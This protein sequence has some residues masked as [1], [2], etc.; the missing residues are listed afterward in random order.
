MAAASGPR[1]D[2]SGSSWTP[3]SRLG[4]LTTR[5]P[6]SSKPSDEPVPLRVVLP[7]S[8]DELVDAGLAVHEQRAGHPEPDPERRG[9]RRQSSSSS[10]PMRRAADH[11]AT[12]QGPSERRPVGAAL[13]EPGV[14][15]G[16][17]GDGPPE[18]TLGQLPVALDFGQLGHAARVPKPG[19]GLR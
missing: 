19:A 13:D 11:P 5:E 16:D 8:V 1:P 4:S 12:D 6:P 7:G 10:L 15:S 9:V 3:P 2:T 14:G 18:G 17:R